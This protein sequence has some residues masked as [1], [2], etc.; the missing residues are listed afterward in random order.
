MLERLLNW[1]SFEKEHA[2]WPVWLNIRDMIF[3]WDNYFLS[4]FFTLKPTRQGS[5][6]IQ[7]WG[8]FKLAISFLRYAMLTWSFCFWSCSS[9]FILFRNQALSLIISQCIVHLACQLS[10]DCVV[11]IHHTCF[12]SKW[13]AMFWNYSCIVHKIFVLLYMSNQAFCFWNSGHV[14]VQPFICWSRSGMY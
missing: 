9:P 12:S 8:N 10:F 1:Y 2:S 14:P 7:I 4:S 5:L 3:E 6:A 11:F 13:D